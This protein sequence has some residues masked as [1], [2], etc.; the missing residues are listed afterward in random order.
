MPE[1]KIAQK[2]PYKV[3]LEANKKYSWCTCGESMIQPFCDGTH[4][5]V[6]VFKSLPFQ[7]EEEKEYYICGCKLT[8]TPP[9]CDGTHKTC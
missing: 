8:S 7:V 4:K 5:K 6:G 9:F 2:A 1:P 3:K